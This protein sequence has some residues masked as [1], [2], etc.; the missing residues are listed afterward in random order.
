MSCGVGRRRSLDPALLW[1]WCRPAFAQSS[2]FPGS[3]PPGFIAVV[4]VVVIIIIM[5]SN[6]SSIPEAE[7]LLVREGP[8][9]FP[10]GTAI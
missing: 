10:G 3:V 6:Y 1:L 2:Q 4:V 9:E 8:G 7:L 5:V